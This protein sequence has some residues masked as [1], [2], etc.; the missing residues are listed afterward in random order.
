VKA[1]LPFADRAAGAEAIF[2]YSSARASK[3]RNAIAL[4]DFSEQGQ[5]HIGRTAV[6]APLSGAVER[7]V[8][9]RR[10]ASGTVVNGC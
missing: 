10:N 7:L 5:P 6:S 9:G 8:L 1:K 3:R 2:R 4:P